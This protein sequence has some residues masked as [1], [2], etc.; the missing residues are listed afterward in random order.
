M[1]KNIDRIPL[2]SIQFSSEPPSPIKPHIK[3][4]KK[5]LP[6]DFFTGE[7]GIHSYSSVVRNSQGLPPSTSSNTRKNVK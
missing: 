5:K 2:S 7:Q 3:I 6:M 4:V 1:I